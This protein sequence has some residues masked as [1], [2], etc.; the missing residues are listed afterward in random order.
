MDRSAGSGDVL[1][2]APSALAWLRTLT[3]SQT[4]L[5]FL[6]ESEL[7]SAEAGAAGSLE[8]DSR[9]GRGG[10]GPAVQP[11][12]DGP[13]PFPVRPC[14]PALT[15]PPMTFSV[16]TAAEKRFPAST[17]D[18]MLSPHQ[19]SSAASQA[20]PCTC[21]V[22]R[23]KPAVASAGTCGLRPRRQGCAVNRNLPTK[24]LGGSLMTR[25]LTLSHIGSI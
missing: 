12:E 22:T 10:R 6:G 25:G 20:G 1:E 17:Q 23:P 9:Q 7:V 24:A 13:C 4:T 2:A 5:G 19:E 8:E 11:R 18:R 16:L 3:D 15:W 14:S 21:P